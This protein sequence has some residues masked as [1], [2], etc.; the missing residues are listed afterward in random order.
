MAALALLATVPRVPAQTNFGTALSFS[1]AGRFVHLGPSAPVLGPH[2]TQEAWIKPELRDARQHG[3][4]G[5]QPGPASVSSP[6]LYVLATNRLVGGFGDGT[7]WHS[8]TS[9]NVLA[10]NAWNHVAATY[11]GA[12]YRVYVNGELVLTHDLAAV[13]TPT[14]VCVVGHVLEDDFVGSMDEVRLWSVARSQGEIQAGMRQRLTGTEPGLLA[15]YGFDEGGGVTAYDTSANHVNGTLIDRPVRVPS[16]W[17]PVIALNGPDPLTNECHAAFVDPTTTKT[18][19]VGIAAGGYHSLALKADGSIVAWGFSEEGRT[20][21]PASASS[22]VVAIA[23][24]EYH[25]LTLKADGSVVAWGSSGWGL[26]TIPSGVTS[27]VVAIA[28]G[29]DHNLA[30]KANGSVVGWGDNSNGQIAIPAS[31]SNGVAAIAACKNHSLALK[32]DGSVV[33]WGNNNG[34]QITIPAS[35][36]S[37]VVAIAAGQFHSL[38]LKADGSVVGWGAG[39]PGTSGAVDYGQTTIPASASS[40]VVAIAAGRNHSLA[41][42]ADGSVVGWGGNEYGQSTVPA[43]VYELNLPLAVSGTVDTN[44]PGIYPLTYNVTNALGRDATATRSVVVTDTLP[45]TLTRLGDHP[46]VVYC[47]SAFVDPGVMA[48]DLCGGDLTAAV[49]VTGNVNTSLPGIYELTYAVADPGGHTVSTNRTVHVVQFP[50]T[51]AGD[52]NGDGLVDQAEFD[53]VAQNYWGS[54]SRPCMTNVVTDGQGLFQMALTNAAAWNFSV[55]VSTNLEDWECLGPA[56]P[57]LEFFDPDATNAPQ[58]FYRLNWP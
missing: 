41:L 6:C 2:F 19:P 33:G 15:C 12:A 48:T 47:G 37:E 8:W 22:G 55:E 25:S 5:Y 43:R 32:L 54:A 13:P 29:A 23:A 34:G 35:A 38:A 16:I 11:D 21:I 18:F 39:G 9:T 56:W 58:R 46:L 42:K 17:T 26:T 52:A 36:S 14:P 28:A 40:G 4:L 10:N 44:T 31:A 1:G 7:N 45:P 30:L 49:V 50:S 51:T 3:L 24:A 53:A 57:A 27:G 20:D